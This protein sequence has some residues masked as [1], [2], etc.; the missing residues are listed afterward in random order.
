MNDFYDFYSLFT[1]QSNRNIQIKCYK[2]YMR[3]R[4]KLKKKDTKRKKN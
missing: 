3:K 2:K 1:C 4:N